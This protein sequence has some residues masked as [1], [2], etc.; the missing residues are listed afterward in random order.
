MTHLSQLPR[1][2]ED[3]SALPSTWQPSPLLSQGVEKFGDHGDGTLH[4]LLRCRMF[5]IAQD[6]AYHILPVP[7]PQIKKN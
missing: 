5:I 7:S 2:S 3:F 6:S 1:V 4:A